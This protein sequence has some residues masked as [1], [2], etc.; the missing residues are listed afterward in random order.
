[1]CLLSAVITL[2]HAVSDVTCKL[3]PF[4]PTNVAER[5]IQCEGAPILWPEP[6]NLPLLPRA[7][8]Y[9]RGL[10]FGSCPR[11][12]Y[13]KSDLPR[14][15]YSGLQQETF[16][17]C[18]QKGPKIFMILAINRHIMCLIWDKDSHTAYRTS[19]ATAKMHQSQQYIPCDGCQRTL[20]HDL[21]S[22]PISNV[23]LDHTQCEF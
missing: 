4:K 5:R 13:R 17:G 11:L 16:C 10:H 3:R 23:H 22:V 6:G 18:L 15:Y 1:M 19:Y 8:L 14:S 7:L 20:G 12:K 9:T 21:R 2:I